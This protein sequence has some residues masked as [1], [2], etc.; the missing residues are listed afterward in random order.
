MALPEQI[1]VRYVDEDA[2]YVSVRPVVKQTFRLRELVDMVVSVAGKDAS[3]LQQILQSGTVV[4]NGYRYTWESIT[5]LPREL[6]V[7]L[8]PFPDDEPDRPFVSANV[9][10]ATLESGGGTQR[11]V[12][13]I[14]RQAASHKKLFRKQSPWDV[15]MLVGKEFPARYERY[16]YA[17]KADLFR[18]AVPYE[19]AQELLRSMLDSAPRSLRQQWNMLR[20][21]AIVT[22]VCPRN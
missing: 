19:K 8:L 15:L 2:G 16:S 11:H 14:T 1:P 12:V 17:R 21:P 6:E 5:A 20:P 3:R 4:Y 10:S 9:L 13:E 18:S 22:F 7:L